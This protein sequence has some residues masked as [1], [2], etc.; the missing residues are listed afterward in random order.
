MAVLCALMNMTGKTHITVT[1]ADVIAAT[2]SN[3]LRIRS[4]DPS[5]LDIYLVQQPGEE[6]VG[7]DY[8]DPYIASDEK[9]RL[10]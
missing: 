1:A 2:S 9:K 3:A 10:Q 4:V 7:L 5:R 6:H 8:A